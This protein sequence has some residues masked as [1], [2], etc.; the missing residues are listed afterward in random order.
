MYASASGGFSLFGGRET[1]YM[2]AADLYIQAANA[3]R[4]QKMSMSLAPEPGPSA[5]AQASD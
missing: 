4:M 2:D 3:F 1:K 5:P